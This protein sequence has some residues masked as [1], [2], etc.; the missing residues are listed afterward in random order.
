MSIESLEVDKSFANIKR[1]LCNGF[2]FWQEIKQVLIH[3]EKQI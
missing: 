1:D 2:M 3:H